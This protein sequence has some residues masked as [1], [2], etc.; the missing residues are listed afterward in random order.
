MNAEF[1]WWLLLVGIVVGAALTWLVLVDLAARPGPFV[2]D[3]SELDLEADWVAARFTEQERDVDRADVV[4]TL[5]LDRLYRSDVP[6]LA[7]TRPRVTRPSSA[8]ADED[9]HDSENEK[10]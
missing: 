5:R 4:D 3:D 7:P 1:N 2:P 8:A 10:T 6:R 9:E